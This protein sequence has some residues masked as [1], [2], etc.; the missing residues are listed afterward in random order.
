ME[1]NNIFQK[2]KPLTIAAIVLF[3]SVVISCT[4]K[5]HWHETIIDL[6]GSTIVVDDNYVS[7]GSIGAYI[8]EKY[9]KLDS[10]EWQKLS[11]KIIVSV[12]TKVGVVSDLK[13]ELRNVEVYRVVFLVQEDKGK[14]Q[15][16]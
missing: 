8:T 10:L 9:K 12:N 5:S 13:K 16:F 6:R 14:T 4:E 11:A 1:M 15:G 7:E 3:F 2:L